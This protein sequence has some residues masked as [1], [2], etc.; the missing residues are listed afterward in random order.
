MHFKLRLGRLQIRE[1]EEMQLKVYARNCFKRGMM[2]K[3]VK[4]VR[5]ISNNEKVDG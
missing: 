5:E 2:N 4:E 1:R 3:E